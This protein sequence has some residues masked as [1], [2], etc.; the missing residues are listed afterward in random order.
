MDCSS[1]D[2]D[3]WV[4]YSAAVAG[5]AAGRALPPAPSIAAALAGTQFAPAAAA[6]AP[7]SG[8]GSAAPKRRKTGTVVPRK[9][10]GKATVSVVS[11]ASAGGAQAAPCGALVR[12]ETASEKAMREF[13]ERDRTPY[14]DEDYPS[15]A[16]DGEDLHLDKDDS[17]YGDSDRSGDD[18]A[19]RAPSHL[20]AALRR[21]MDED[22][23]GAGAPVKPVRKRPS[24]LASGTRAPGAAGGKRGGG[25]GAG[26]RGPKSAVGG[27]GGGAGAGGGRSGGTKPG[28]GGA[29]KPG[30]KP[31]AK[32][33]AAGAKPKPV[34]G[35]KKPAA[36]VG[37]VK[38]QPKPAA[39]RVG[40]KARKPVV[41]PAGGKRGVGAKPKQPT[42]PRL[43]KLARVAV[44]K[45]PKTP[46]AAKL[47]VA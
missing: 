40:V 3:S 14:R 15:D 26:A 35:A 19:Y 2:E 21:A 30:G 45:E 44:K 24:K 33:V 8:E 5:H 27:S 37:V 42:L 39:A 28:A 47:P 9:A 38:R 23:A 18:E 22:A 25:A 7:T 41:A 1:S 29:A 17:D 34:A 10:R 6:A 13:K 32:P 46:K 43:P 31:R 20:A 36:P 12:A 16:D 4:P 11:G